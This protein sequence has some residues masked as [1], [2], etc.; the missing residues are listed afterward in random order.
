MLDKMTEENKI[1]A[2]PSPAM[3]GA[4]ASVTKQANG[5]PP[6]NNQEQ[7]WPAQHKAYDQP[8]IERG[9]KDRDFDQKERTDMEALSMALK[10]VKRQV[11]EKRRK[12]EELERQ[13]NQERFNVHAKKNTVLTQ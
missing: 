12:L 9:F 4:N 8:A 2:L 10:F 1:D 3:S 5:A 11:S 13:V 7:F 6:G